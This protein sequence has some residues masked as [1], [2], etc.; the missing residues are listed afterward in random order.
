[1]LFFIEFVCLIDY[2]L[3]LFALLMMD[4][5]YLPYLHSKCQSPEVELKVGSA[6]RSTPQPRGKL[7]GTTGMFDRI[8]CSDLKYMVFLNNGVRVERNLMIFL[9]TLARKCQRVY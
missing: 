8:S 7:S 3:I 5:F 1:M 9:I 2:G 6:V 4:L